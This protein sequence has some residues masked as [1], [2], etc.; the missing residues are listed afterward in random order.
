MPGSS[1]RVRGR[2]PT[3]WSAA[4]RSAVIPGDGRGDRDGLGCS[5]T[6][7]CDS[8]PSRAAERRAPAAL[9]STRPITVAGPAAVS[10]SSSSRWSCIPGSLFSYLRCERGLGAEQ[11]GGADA[12]LSRTDRRR[13]SVSRILHRVKGRGREGELRSSVGSGAPYTTGGSWW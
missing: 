9:D 12:L 3:G 1:D 2:Q 13:A 7:S 6:M 4:A 5:L 11:S 10:V 8:R